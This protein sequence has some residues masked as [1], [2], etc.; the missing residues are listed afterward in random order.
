MSTP[1]VA[2]TLAALLELGGVMGYVR[3][4]S[5]VSFIA[6]TTT[7][8]IMALTVP[9]LWKNA[10]HKDANRVAGATTLLLTAI[11]GARYL[12][13]KTTVPLVVSLVNGL[14]FLFAFAPNC[15]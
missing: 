13:H 12:K 1:L 9:F 14:S 7:S 10:Y 3:K 6:G 15:F 4:G 2:A 11:M 5:K 8:L